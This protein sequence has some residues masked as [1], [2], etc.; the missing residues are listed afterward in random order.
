[1]QAPQDYRDANDD[2]FKRLCFW[3]YAGFFHLGMKTRDEKNAIIQHGTMALIR[4]SALIEV[5][6][7]GE[8]CIT[9]DAELGLRLFKAGYRAVYTEHSYGKGLMP[10]SFDAY[11][12]QR[13][14]W[15][16]GAMT[17]MKRHMRDL[18]PFGR[19]AARCGASSATS[20][21]PAG[22]RGSPTACNCCSSIWRWPGAP[23]C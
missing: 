8:W 21:W 12:K 3:E 5:G 7:W 11:R 2:L 9:E 19:G 1:M 20:S 15:A 4:K 22:C 6:G 10:D 16:Y 13:Y 18:L 17:I 23:A 14:R